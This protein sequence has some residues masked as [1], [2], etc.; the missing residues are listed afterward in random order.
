MRILWIAPGLVCSHIFCFVI[1]ALTL[2]NNSFTEEID[3]DTCKLSVFDS[4][5]MVE[6][7]ADC[8]VCSCEEPYCQQCRR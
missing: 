4:G 2:H 1:V 6:F 8:D 3:T 7:K 5:Q